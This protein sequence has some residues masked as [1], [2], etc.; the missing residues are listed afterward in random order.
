MIP[1]SLLTTFDILKYTQGYLLEKEDI[2]KTKGESLKVQSSCLNEDLGQ[3]NY[4]FSDKTG[5]LTKNR[6]VFRLLF[7]NGKHYGK[8]PT[9][10]ELYKP[11]EANE[12]EK[13]KRIPFVNF[14]DEHIFID[15]ANQENKSLQ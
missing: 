12:K 14:E 1:I 6:M 7:G 13:K 8:I 11:Q 15:S 5:T 10:E 3:I 4:I 9:Q 2:F